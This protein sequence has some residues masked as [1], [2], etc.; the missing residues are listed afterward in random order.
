MA[1]HDVK[2]NGTS[3]TGVPYINIPTTGGDTATFYGLPSLYLPPSAEL[4]ASAE[5]TLNL[6]ADTSFDSWTPSTTQASIKAAGSARAACSYK[7]TTDYQ[8]TALMGFCSMQTKY[9]YPDGT[10]YA[11][12]YQLRKSMFGISYYAPTK[13]DGNTSDYYGRVF[14]GVGF[15]QEY[16]SSATAVTMYTG[17]AYGIGCTGTAWGTSSATSTSARTVG[18]ARPVI[19]ARCHSTYFSTTAAAAVDSANTNIVF[20]YR[21]YKMDKTENPLYT[22][23]DGNNGELY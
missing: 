22:L 6:S 4:V 14:S 2:I 9:A 18:F 23:F 11:K 3:Y 8:D 21:I 7:I 19:Y 5:E 10:T 13:L 15:N 17:S 1:T 16:H 12:G 20:K